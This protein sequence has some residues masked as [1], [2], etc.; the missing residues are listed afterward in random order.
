MFLS[1]NWFIGI[2]VTLLGMICDI[3]VI[4]NVTNVINVTRLLLVYWIY[5]MNGLFEPE[6]TFQK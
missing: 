4:I 1:D 2:N 5:K 3:L 6:S